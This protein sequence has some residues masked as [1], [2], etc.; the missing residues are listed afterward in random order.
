MKK[1]TLRL[2][3]ILLSLL[4]A[5][6][7][8][9][10]CGGTTTP[11]ASSAPVQSQSTEASSAPA[12][13]ASAEATPEAQPKEEVTLSILLQLGNSAYINN[14]SEI[15]KEIAKRTGVKLD[16][17]VTQRNE[18]IN[19]IL[20]ILTAGGDLPDIVT[21]TLGEQ[22]NSLIT[23]NSI[24]NLDD[25]LETYGKNILANGE[26]GLAM[27]RVT[28]SNG[29]NN[30][31]FLTGG[32][33]YVPYNPVWADKG[34]SIRWDL[35]KQLGYPEMKTMDQFLDVLEKMM[36]LEPTTPE[37][38]KTYGFGGFFG[39]SWGYV[40]PGQSETN[41]W[42]DLLTGV[43]LYDLK[44]YESKAQFETL[45]DPMFKSIEF[46]NKAYRKGILDPESLAMKFG[47]YQD[48]SKT[49]KYLATS[50][51]W[52][53]S[54]AMNAK[55]VEAGTPEKGF[56]QFIIGNTS[57]AA[58]IFEGTPYGSQFQFAVSKNCKTPERAVELFD[59]LYTE[60]GSMLLKY[61][62]EGVHYTKNEDGS[63]QGI[64]DASIE[65]IAKD[66]NKIK[67]G[68]GVYS[69][70]VMLD[71]PAVNVLNKSYTKENLLPVHKDFCSYYGVDL[72]MD[73]IT[74]GLTHVNTNASLM[75]AITPIAGTD[76]A[77]ILASVNA[78]L[79]TGIAKMVFQ[80]SEEKF[81]KEKVDFKAKI[82]EMGFDKLTEFYKT[83][84]KRVRAL[85]EGN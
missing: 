23:S 6:T 2:S 53:G 76:I 11:P 43:V 46:W 27:N 14:D 19:Q 79:P 61:G 7:A 21:V 1:N 77:D 33:G 37:G 62:I 35:Y 67:T 39:E 47:D 80:D 13:S 42:G 10:G 3:A 68:V 64:G 60:E 57:G 22:V 69:N 63:V 51:S 66:E 75:P 50:L 55:Y 28:R 56:T 36:A 84:Y 15:M 26:L 45:D 83:E 18:D 41:V 81:E 40:I 71:T 85:V 74:K 52:M 38:K 82:T 54:S 25:Y 5:I 24:Y 48:I 17:T 58:N 44:T 20:P 12:E 65:N 29:T 59:Y 9:S 70:F 49:G 4:F 73:Q 32:F 34:W 16:W 8:L 31:Y 30:L 78:Y 72:P